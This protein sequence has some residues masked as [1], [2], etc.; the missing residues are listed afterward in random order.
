MSFGVA[1]FTSS[2]KAAISTMDY[3][4]DANVT[5]IEQLFSQSRMTLMSNVLMEDAK[6][7]GMLP[8]YILQHTHHYNIVVFL[9][10]GP[11]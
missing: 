2:N 10:V 4:Y 8:P 5:K 9:S 11:C 6:S 3:P 7:P 1:C